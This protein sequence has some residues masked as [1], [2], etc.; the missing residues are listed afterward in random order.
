MVRGGVESHDSPT[1]V[2][3]QEGGRSLGSKRQWFGSTIRGPDGI[4]LAC[5]AELHMHKV[6]LV[7]GSSSCVRA[8]RWV[9]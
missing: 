5:W 4:L 6:G 2:S 8:K 3:T 1:G 7:V 9:V